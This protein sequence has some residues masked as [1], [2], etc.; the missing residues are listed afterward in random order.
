MTLNALV[1]NKMFYLKCLLLFFMLFSMSN[2]LQ[3]VI[4][5]PSYFFTSSTATPTNNAQWLTVN[6]IIWWPEFDDF[7]K[8]IVSPFFY[9]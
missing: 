3:Y 1:G 6:S 9:S 4:E 8:K 2:M 7:H 5:F